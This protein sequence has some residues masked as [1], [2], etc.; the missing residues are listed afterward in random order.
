LKKG[1]RGILKLFITPN[2]KYQITNE[3]QNQ[4]IK[5]LCLKLDLEFDICY[6]FDIWNLVFDIK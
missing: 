6:W 1:V 5:P 2:S 4:N 3:Y